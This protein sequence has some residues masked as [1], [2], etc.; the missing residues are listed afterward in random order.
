[1]G[2]FSFC[3]GGSK[4]VKSRYRWLEANPATLIH[5]D[6][7]EE[8]HE[9]VVYSLDE[10]KNSIGLALML[11]QGMY[12][13]WCYFTGMR[14]VETQ[15]FWMLPG[16]GWNRINLEHRYIVVNREIA[17][18]KRRRKILIRPNLLEW[19]KYFKAT[20]E[21]P[22]PDSMVTHRRNFRA[23]KLATI[24]PEKRTVRDVIRHTFITYRAHAFDRSFSCTAAEAGNS[25]KI[26]RNHYFDLL[27]DQNAVDEYWSLTPATFGLTTV[28]PEHPSQSVS[29]DPAPPNRPEVLVSN[30][31][32]SSADLSP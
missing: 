5:V 29:T 30:G 31:V 10:V 20:E 25:E 24:A 28:T 3:S 7:S 12:W 23:I 16:Y 18:D 9:I 2:L 26:I 19:L 22:F 6:K 14:P 11:G 4:K 15:K 8:D 21:L 32:H 17:K 13:I 1:M 27:S